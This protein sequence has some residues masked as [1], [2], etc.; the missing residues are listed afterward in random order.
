MSAAN[1]LVESSANGL[2]GD[3]GVM[4]GETTGW[5]GGRG[6]IIK[7]SIMMEVTMEANN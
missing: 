2:L 3:R 5:T 6:N 4:A 1:G 7:L